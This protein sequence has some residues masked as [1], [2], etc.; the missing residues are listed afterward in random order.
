MKKVGFISEIHLLRALACLMILMIHV[1]GYFYYTNGEEHTSFSLLLNQV[2]RVGTLLFMMISGFLLFY[3]AKTKGFNT[4]YFLRSRITKVLI[5]FLFWTLFY[6]YLS[7]QTI[8]SIEWGWD[9]LYATLFL[10]KGFYHLWFMVVLIQ[11]YILFPLMQRLIKQTRDWIITMGISLGIQLFFILELRDPTLIVPPTV[12]WDKAYL[13]NWIFYFI[14]GGFFAQHWEKIRDWAQ[15]NEKLFLFLLVVL[16]GE[17]L[18]SLSREG[19]LSELRLFALISTPLTLLAII[20]LYPRVKKWDKLLSTFNF[21][22]KYSMGIYIIHPFLL[23]FS[24]YLPNIFWESSMLLV[25]FLF[26]L[27]LSILLLKGLEKLPLHQYVLPV[28]KPKRY[29][30]QSALSLVSIIFCQLWFK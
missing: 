23:F 6:L 28:S 12:A 1:T 29:A 11:F 2:S 3:Q 21:I 5:P 4:A 26:Y 20:S 8:F 25:T 18:W 13:F 15:R 19:V 24:S 9:F 14:L 16:L 27:V 10:G 30:S 22:G 7:H 17:A